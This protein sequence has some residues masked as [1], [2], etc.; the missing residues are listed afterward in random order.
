MQA[1]DLVLIEVP[2]QP[3]NGEVGRIVEIFW[4]F[5]TAQFGPDEA[6]FWVYFSDELSVLENSPS[7]TSPAKSP[8]EVALAKFTTSTAA[9]SFTKSDCAA[10]G[11]SQ[12][13]TYDS[14]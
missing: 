14:R 13:G 10:A 6:N 11:H 1:G 12:P 5:V 3:H 8:L 7:T 4:C 9:F 2:G